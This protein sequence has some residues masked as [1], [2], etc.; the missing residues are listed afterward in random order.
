[1]PRSER[2][3][4]NGEAAFEQ[5]FGVHI[6]TLRL[7]KQRE[8]VETGTDS[9]MRRAKH[10]LADGD[11]ALRQRLGLGIAAL[12]PVEACEISETTG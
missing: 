7:I 6:A 8:V 3:L 10:L 2:L 12:G 9:R 5:R 1:M 11:S 4:G